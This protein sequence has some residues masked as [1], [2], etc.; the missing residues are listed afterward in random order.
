MDGLP[1]FTCNWLHSRAAA[2]SLAILAPLEIKTCHVIFETRLEKI[3]SFLHMRKK[4]T[5]QLRGNHT[6]D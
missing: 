2:F 4:G 3:C 6:A 1:T 5:D